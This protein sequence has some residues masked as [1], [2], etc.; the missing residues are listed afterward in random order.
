M[1]FLAKKSFQMVKRNNLNQ[2][3]LL[4]DTIYLFGWVYSCADQLH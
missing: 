2:I 1:Q 3:V 4:R